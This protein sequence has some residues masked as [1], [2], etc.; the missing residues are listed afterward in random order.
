M[1]N[2]TKR[3]LTGALIVLAVVA[4]IWIHPYAFLSLFAF[5]AILLMKEM[6]EMLGVKKDSLLLINSIVLGAG[7]FI[8]SF[9][10]FYTGLSAKWMLFLVLL[11]WVPFLIVLFSRYENPFR[12]VA[13]YLL[14][15]V[16]ISL[17]LFS[18]NILAFAEGGYDRL[19]IL[20]F[21]I[22][23]WI[24]D[25][26]A[27]LVGVNFGK[28]RLF[29]RISPKKSWEGFWGGLILTTIAAYFL[30]LWVQQGSM[31]L[32][33]VT[34]VMVSVFATLGDLVESMLKRSVNIK[35]SGNIL[36]GHGGLFDRFDGALFAAPVMSLLFY[37]F[38]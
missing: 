2:F 14:I 27:Y 11:V 21:F 37:F 35:D 23:V 1:N 5:S 20:S 26:G 8:L 36:P 34:G 31:V 10:H 32:W 16:Y 29:E 15:A 7:I 17:P 12:M 4:S 9:L 13:S 19:L 3:S 28:R 38:G 22:M 18:L 25:T 33:L 30:F 6:E 24:N